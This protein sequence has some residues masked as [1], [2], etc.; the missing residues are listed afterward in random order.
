MEPAARKE[1]P[2][3]FS[4]CNISLVSKLTCSAALPDTR[5]QD[6]DT[7]TVTVDILHLCNG[8]AMIQRIINWRIYYYYH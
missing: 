7:D 2:G 1:L 3:I 4:R 8:F 6:T 5:K